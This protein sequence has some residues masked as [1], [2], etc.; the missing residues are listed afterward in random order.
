MYDERTESVRHVR[1]PRRWYLIHEPLAFLTGNHAVRERTKVDGNG[2]LSFVSECRLLRHHRRAAPSRSER[3][4]QRAIWTCSRHGRTLDWT[5]PAV[6]AARGSWRRRTRYLWLQRA[7]GKQ[8]GRW[9]PLWWR[10]NERPLWGRRCLGFPSCI[11][12]LV[13]R[14]RR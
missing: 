10:W 1:R 3:H 11:R 7:M 4:V 2:Q 12:T 14:W 13:S 6:D 8:S 9:G 5:E